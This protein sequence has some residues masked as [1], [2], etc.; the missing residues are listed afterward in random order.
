MALKKGILEKSWNKRKKRVFT[1]LV[2]ASLAQKYFK[3]QKKWCL[4][5]YY[6]IHANHAYIIFYIILLYKYNYIDNV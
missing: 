1:S 5:I 6:Y 4:T 3:T 2:I